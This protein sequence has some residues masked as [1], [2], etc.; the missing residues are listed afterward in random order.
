MEVIQHIIRKYPELLYTN[1]D[2]SREFC[3]QTPLH[4]AISKEDKVIVAMLLDAARSN[5]KTKQRRLKEYLSQKATGLRFKSNVM[6]G[7]L[8]LSVAV[9]T[10][11]KKIVKL[12]LDQWDTDVYQQNSTNDNL[13]HSILKYLKMF[14]DQEDKAIEMMRFINDEK[15]ACCKKLFLMVNEDKE[16]PLMLAAKYEQFEIFHYIIEKGYCISDESSGLFDERLYDMKDVDHQ[17]KESKRLEDEKEIKNDLET[18]ANMVTP[19]E[20]NIRVPSVFDLIFHHSG[21]RL[22]SV[23]FFLR[24][25]RLFCFFTSLIQRTMFPDIASFAFVIAIQ[26]VAFSTTM[27]MFLHDPNIP[28]SDSYSSWEG[29]LMLTFK[30]FLGVADIPISESSEPV[31]LSIVFVIFIIMTAIM[32]LNALIAI[33]SST[34]TDLLTH[35]TPYMHLYL[36]QLAIILFFEEI[37]PNRVTHY[38]AEK[39]TKEIDVDMYD[40]ERDRIR[41]M[42]RHMLRIDVM[43]DKEGQYY[44]NVETILHKLTTAVY[45]KFTGSNTIKESNSEPIKPIRPKT[46]SKFTMTKAVEPLDLRKGLEIYDHPK[47]EQTNSI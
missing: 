42:K 6:M 44:E 37:L 43:V 28:N 38:F 9:L 24:A 11:N 18:K 34:C 25:Y 3:G 40:R 21:Y 32:M 17:L 16:T 31:L 2:N 33:I 19:R 1:R 47:I 22:V 20:K 35:F 39:V 30:S 12:L 10:G 7:Q 13:C 29:M 27:F 15:E 46:N 26:L 36:Q 14:P 23:A 5:Y 8:P 41:T 4:M 45:D